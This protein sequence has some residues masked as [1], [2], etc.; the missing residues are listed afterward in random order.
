VALS[1]ETKVNTNRLLSL[2]EQIS[3]RNMPRRVFDS[4]SDE[5][6]LKKITLVGY[7]ALSKAGVCLQVKNNQVVFLPEIEDWDAD[8]LE[9][10]VRVTGVLHKKK[11]VPDVVIDDE[12]GI[13]QGSFGKHYQL[14][15][16]NVKKIEVVD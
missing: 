13:S 1:I 2:R 9:Q 5:L 15:N 10:K 7:A 8:F 16:V 4:V 14:S 6:I 11:I 3:V 12:G